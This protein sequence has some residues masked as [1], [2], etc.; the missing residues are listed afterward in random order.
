MGESKLSMKLLSYN[1]RGSRKEKMREVRELE[2][3]IESVN[4]K[5]CKALWGDRP[6]EW[7]CLGSE[8]NVGVSDWNRKGMVVVNGRWIEDGSN[9]T[10]VNVYAPN[11]LA[12][13]WE[14][15][16]CIQVLVEQY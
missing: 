15:W 11:I 13:R 10:I 9:C 16:E 14:L 3:K 5:F 1:L 2:T 12:Q 7:E 6:C 4:K 8:G